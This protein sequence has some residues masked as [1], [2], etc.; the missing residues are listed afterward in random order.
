MWYSVSASQTR[1]HGGPSGNH[2]CEDVKIDSVFP[3]MIETHIRA[4]VIADI[5]EE[6]KNFDLFFLLKIDSIRSDELCASCVKISKNYTLKQ[7]I[8]KS[9]VGQSRPTDQH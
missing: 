6:G 1:Q 9:I 3:N 5:C 8:K 2:T 7:L 4:I